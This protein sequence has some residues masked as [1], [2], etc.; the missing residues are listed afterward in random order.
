[1]LE[2][3]GYLLGEQL[4]LGQRSVVYRARRRRDDQPVVVKILHDEYPSAEAV[5]RFKREFEIGRSLE[6]HGTVRFLAME[7]VD[8]TWAIVMED[9]G[10]RALRSLLGARR[11]D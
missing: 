8:R 10:A 11:L 2:I 5:A 7:P 1:M 4:H 3:V 6:G 9:K